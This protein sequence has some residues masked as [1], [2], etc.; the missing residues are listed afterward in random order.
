MADDPREA[1]LERFQAERGGHLLQGAMLLT[2]SK[3][4]G[5][6]LAQAAPERLLRR[7]RPSRQGRPTDL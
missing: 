6:D 3:E 5:E 1:E 2:G 4:A 7:F